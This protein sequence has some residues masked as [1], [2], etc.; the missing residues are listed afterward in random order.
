MIICQQRKLAPYV[1][2]A[3]REENITVISGDV[4]MTDEDVPE[5]K[6][7]KKRKICASYF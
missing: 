6:K 1:E 3:R 5:I 4:P 7:I 2:R